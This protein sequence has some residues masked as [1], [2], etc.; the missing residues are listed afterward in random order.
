MIPIWGKLA[1]HVG[2]HVVLSPEG[3][4]L[5]TSPGTES[6]YPRPP[7]SLNNSI[8]SACITKTAATALQ[9]SVDLDTAA[10]SDDH[11][12]TNIQR[13]GGTRNPWL[14]DRTRSRPNTQQWGVPKRPVIHSAMRHLSSPRHDI[15]GK[16]PLQMPHSGR[17]GRG[18]C[19]GKM[20]KRTS[21]GTA[22]RSG[23]LHPGRNLD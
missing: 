7:Q 19:V 10:S 15:A 2:D 14:N 20:G 8:D 16:T 11:V 4:A 18:P 9:T 5:V 3:A 13:E 17:S 22:I 23:T 1:D 6:S 12:E 21:L